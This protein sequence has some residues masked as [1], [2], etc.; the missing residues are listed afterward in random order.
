MPGIPLS[1]Y[2]RCCLFPKCVP[3][4]VSP[5]QAARHH[6]RRRTV[7]AVPVP[8]YRRTQKPRQCRI[9]VLVDNS[10]HNT[11]RRPGQHTRCHFGH[12]TLGQNLV[13]SAPTLRCEYSFP[14]TNQRSTALRPTASACNSTC[15]LARP[16]VLRTVCFT[17]EPTVSTRHP[18]EKTPPTRIEA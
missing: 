13:R 8:K 16:E 3:V 18:P 6:H 12:N 5:L 11:R 1:Q 17:S 2:S 15:H 4:P 7:L 10:D 14:T 9:A